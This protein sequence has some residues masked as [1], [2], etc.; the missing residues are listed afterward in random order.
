M[1]SKRNDV[2]LGTHRALVR[3]DRREREGAQRQRLAGGAVSFVVGVVLVD[4][5]R[6]DVR[7]RAKAAGIANGGNRDP[8]LREEGE[9]RGEAPQQPAAAS[10]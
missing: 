3:H 9:R 5:V 7:G 6:L 1:R 10:G 4:P 2:R 8:A